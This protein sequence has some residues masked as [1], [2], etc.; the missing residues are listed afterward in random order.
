MKNNVST[1]TLYIFSSDNWKRPKEEIDFLFLII[2]KYL[3]QSQL[4]YADAGVKIKIIGRKDRIPMSLLKQIQETEELTKH[5]KNL[6]LNFCID[7]DGKEE[8]L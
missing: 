5:N 6:D 3:K 7:Y 8:I 1:L 4:H 2:E